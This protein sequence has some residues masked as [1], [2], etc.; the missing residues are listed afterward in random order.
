MKPEY[1]KILRRALFILGGAG[2]G[3]AWYYFFGCT[4]GCM[5][6]SSPL[7]SMAYVA[8]M[9]LLL[10]LATEKEAKDQCNT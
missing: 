3:Y 6:S 5:I 7:R 4:S 9:G 2:A 10:S 8:V 1:K